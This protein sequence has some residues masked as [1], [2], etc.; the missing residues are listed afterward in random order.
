MRVK[1]ARRVTSGRY[2][3][4]YM[5]DTLVASPSMAATSAPA[6]PPFT[7][8]PIPQQV[9]KTCVSRFLDEVHVRNIGA[10]TAFARNSLAVFGVVWIVAK[11]PALKSTKHGFDPR[12]VARSGCIRKVRLFACKH[13][14]GE[15]LGN[16][17][18]CHH[19][20]QIERIIACCPHPAF[21]VDPVVQCG[22]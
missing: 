1:R 11:K 14:R 7:K 16:C 13:G 21:H 20:L 19:S 17:Q 15:W 12:D 10:A 18:A 4:R 8:Q 2:S 3:E 5:I 9:D 22:P 6:W